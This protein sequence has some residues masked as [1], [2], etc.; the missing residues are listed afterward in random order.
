MTSVTTGHTENTNPQPFLSARRTWIY[1]AGFCLICLLAISRQ[2]L[3]VD[4]AGTALKAQQPTVQEWWRTLYSINGSDLQMPLYMFWIWIFGHIFGTSELALRAV[5]LFWFAPGLIALLHVFAGRSR[6]QLAIFLTAISSPFAW[7]YLNEA[8]PYAMQLGTGLF[9]AAALCHWSQKSSAAANE[10]VWIWSFVFALIALSGSS[11]LGMIWAA[12]PLL[13]AFFLLPKDRLLT[14]GRRYIFAWL[15]ALVFLIAL[16]IYYLWTLK[17]GAR[18]SD[19]ATTGWKNVV[20]IGYELLGFTGLGPGRLEIRADSG[21]H[22]FKPYLLALALYAALILTLLLLAVRNL[23]EQNVRKKFLGAA[24]S[25]SAPAVFILGVG[26][27]LTF[28]VLGRHFAPLFPVVILLLA[29]GTVAAWQRGQLGKIIVVTFFAFNLASC[30]CLRFEARH[31]KDDYRSA[32]ALASD[33]LAKGQRV[34]WNA[35]ENGAVYYHLPLTKD[36]ADAKKAFVLF[37]P[38]RESIAAIPQPDVIIASRPDIVDIHG[39]VADLAA[40]KK[41][42]ETT[43][44]PAFIIW[45]KIPSATN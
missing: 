24:L 5:N 40:Q 8:R 41:I 37:D 10:P 22:V 15:T 33:A 18:A 14:L 45:E 1:I 21:L 42:K 4:E 36:P 27:A 44:L 17:A 12:T 31:A 7:Y 9:L 13:A 16:G 11:M 35:A 19:A 29:L 23:R 38:T 28:R 3:W 39:A 25:V 20:F 32:C 30:L 43:V 34:W 2:S 26:V 6:L